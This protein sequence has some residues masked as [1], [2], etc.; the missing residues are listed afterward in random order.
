Q[1]GLSFQHDKP[2]FKV[3]GRLLAIDQTK[4]ALPR[5]GART[6]PEFEKVRRT[7][8]RFLLQRNIKSWGTVTFS[9]SLWGCAKLPLRPEG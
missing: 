8:G 1:C 2:Q 3:G 7:L 6:A 4:V 9:R 5:E